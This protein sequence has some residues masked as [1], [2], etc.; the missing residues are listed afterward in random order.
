MTSAAVVKVG[1]RTYKQEESVVFRKT[2][3]AYGG[4]SNMAPGYP[5]M[6]NGL[7]VRTSEVLYQACRYPHIPEVQEVLLAERSPMTAKMRTKPYRERSRP[8]WE[9][10]R[11]RVMRW[12]LRVK[13]AQNWDKFSRLLLSTAPRPIVELSTR[14]PFWGAQPRDD[15]RL[16]GANVL[17]RLLMELRDEVQ[18]KG[19]EGFILIPPPKLQDVLL[20]GQPIQPVV[21]G[22]RHAVDAMPPLQ[23]TMRGMG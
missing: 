22:N 12:C 9:R 4:L 18:T 2:R 14:D 13:L 16:V 10:A 21:A 8:D 19:H 15:G 6:V 3:E 7:R 11:T 20:L 23:A 1:E 5:L 17:G